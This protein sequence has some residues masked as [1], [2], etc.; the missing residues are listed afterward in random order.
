LLALLATVAH[1]DD[2]LGKR[3]VG[4]R[5][6]G[7][8]KVTEITAMRLGDFEIGQFVTPEMIGDIEEHLLSSELFKT[9]KVTF[10]DVPGGVLVIA[11]VEDKLSWIAAPTLYILP[12]TWSFGVGYAEN[13]L[14]GENKKMLLYGQIGNRTSLFFGT[15]LDPSFRGSPLQLRF[16][17]YTLHKSITEYENPPDD[18][19]STAI[20]RETTMTFLD[21]GVLVG[22]KFR[23]WLSSALRFRGAYVY[24]REPHADDAAQTP[25]PVPSP[26]G[27]DMSLQAQ[28]TADDRAH[29]Y[30]VTWGPYLQLT[31]EAGIPGLDSYDYQ[32]ALMRAYYSWRMFGEHELELRARFDVGH[33]LPIHEEFGLGGASDLR[34]YS[35]DQFRGDVRGSLRVEYSVP[36]AKW[37]MFAFRAIG[38]WDSGFTAFEFRDPDGR[39]DYLPTQNDGAHWFR[40]DVGAGLRVYVSSIVLPLLG[41]DFGYGIE[42]HSPEVYFEV[43]IT[44]F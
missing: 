15:Y 37:K 9:V 8:S 1:A 11:T 43:G 14:L 4:A 16:D 6:R 28:L 18:P 21:A 29:R 24:F 32:V 19:Q 20:A 42:G 3:V 12:G 17:I 27:W 13:D 25:L 30:G 44:D 34:G 39:R 2:G 33:H 35:G 22:W 31:L 5:V 38:F 23:W 10:E 41:L 7:H 26:D 36:I 40:N